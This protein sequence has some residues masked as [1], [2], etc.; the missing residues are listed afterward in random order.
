MKKSI[1]IYPEK[2]LGCRLCELACVFHREKLYNPKRARIRIHLVGI[3]E[4]PGPV[5]SRR[6]D[7]CGGNPQCV[8][9]CPT[10]ALT[11]E[12][13]NPRRDFKTIPDHEEI[14]N[15]WLA[16]VMPKSDEEINESKEENK[17]APA[18]K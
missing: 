14:V 5:I 12:E 17:K 10:G 6:C 18:E 9:I 8:A 16:G 11:Y 7:Q 3:P 15:S 4:L 2:C 1:K 13:D